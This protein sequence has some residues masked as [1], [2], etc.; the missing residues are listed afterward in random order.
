LKSSSQ[1]A[2]A[3]PSLTAS[4]SQVVH[5]HSDPE[6]SYLKFLNETWETTKVKSLEQ[7]KTLSQAVKSLKAGALD[8]QQ[9]EQAQ[10]ITH[11]LADTLGIFGLTKEVQMARHLEHLLNSTTPL[12]SKYAPLIQALVRDLQREIQTTSSIQTLQTSSEH[13]PVLLVVDQDYE[14]TQSLEAAATGRGI[15]TQIAPTIDAAREYLMSEA[16]DAIVLRSSSFSSRQNGRIDPSIAD[17]LKSLR[18][19][20]HHHPSLPILILGNRAEL[21]DR[22]EVLRRGGKLL[23]EQSLTPE[24]IIAFVSQLLEVS[25]PDVKVMIVDGDQAWLQTLPALLKP[26]RFKITT[27]DDPQQFWTVLQTVV[28]DVLV[29]DVNMPEINGFELC[30]VL[31]SDPHWQRLPVLF[32]SALTDSKTQNQAFTVGA[33]DYLCKPV[34]GVDLAKRILNRLQRLRAWTIPLSLSQKIKGCNKP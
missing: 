22:L 16:V 23:L 13:L 2:I 3:E 15:R 20:I 11:K 29:L 34:M 21:V 25:S 17:A 10:Q 14:F 32:L 4:L 27:L 8:R 19:L 26:W 5:H 24:Q 12:Q 9:Q 6:S 18:S 28:P 31:R 30:Q 7:L 33:D 1:D